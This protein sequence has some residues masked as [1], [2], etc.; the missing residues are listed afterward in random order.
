MG[1]CNDG[2]GSRYMAE[3][4]AGYSGGGAG[5]SLRSRGSGRGRHGAGYDD[6]DAG[7]DGATNG[8]YGGYGGGSLEDRD[9]DYRR[10][11]QPV[12][13]QGRTDREFEEYMA[14]QRRLAAQKARGKVR[15]RC[16]DLNTSKIQQQQQYLSCLQSTTPAAQEKPG[17]GDRQSICDCRCGSVP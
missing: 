2:S 9:A 8:G 5:T 15:N 7:L 17:T 12:K 14:A 3:N 10:A 6:E 11:R 4:N 1:S 13:G 16:H